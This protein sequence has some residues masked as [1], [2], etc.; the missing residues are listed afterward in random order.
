[1]VRRAAGAVWGGTPGA[2]APPPAPAEYASS[3]LRCP[4]LKGGAPWVPQA[5]EHP[6]TRVLPWLLA[7]QRALRSCQEPE[8]REGGAKPLPHQ[9]LPLCLQ[10]QR[11]SGQGV[12][13]RDPGPEPDTGSSPPST[14]SP[15]CDV[16]LASSLGGPLWSS[17]SSGPCSV[18]SS[19]KPLLHGSLWGSP[20]GAWG[21]KRQGVDFLARSQGGP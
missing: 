20:A 16:P 15:R 11:N 10:P 12:C 14:L 13:R 21:E 4:R 19:A 2:G 18:T 17:E 1:M 8:H 7:S 3:S 6:K 5:C 9:A